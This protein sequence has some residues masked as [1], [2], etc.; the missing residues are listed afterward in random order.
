MRL[1]ANTIAALPICLH[2]AAL[3]LLNTRSNDDIPLVG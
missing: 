1:V 3:P 2:I